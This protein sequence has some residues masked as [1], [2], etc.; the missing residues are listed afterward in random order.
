MGREANVYGQRRKVNRDYPRPSM[1]SLQGENLV[2]AGVG[3]LEK[4]QCSVLSQVPI[5]RVVGVGEMFWPGLAAPPYVA[6]KSGMVGVLNCKL[7]RYGL[8]PFGLFWD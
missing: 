4:H 5:Q 3:R 8:S 2:P 6:M 7:I 1:R